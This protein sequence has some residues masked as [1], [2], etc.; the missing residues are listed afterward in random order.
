VEITAFRDHPLFATL[1]TAQLERLLP[2]AREIVFPD[3]ALIL[4]EGDVADTLY[5]LRAGCVALEQHFAGR[6][7]VKVESLCAGDILGLSWLLPAGHWTLD[8][9]CQ[10]PV[11]VIAISADCLRTCMHADQALGLD[12][13]T[14]VLEALYRRLTRVRLQRLDV[15]TNGV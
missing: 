2:C 6:G 15:Y 1:T 8:A 5:V 13:L 11:E 7:V 14:H 3:D 4:R 9:R 12:L 10:G